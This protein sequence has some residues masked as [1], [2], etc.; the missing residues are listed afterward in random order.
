MLTN[1]VT[2]NPKSGQNSGFSLIELLIALAIAAII[3]SIALPS[4]TNFVERSKMRTAQADLVALTVNIE[5]E[6]QRTLVYPSIADSVDLSSRYTGWNPTSND[7][8]YSA[9]S[10][11]TGYTITATGKNSLAGCTLTV[12][13]NNAR[14]ATGCPQSSGDWI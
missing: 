5:N 2:N 11:A 4:Y 12:N 3:T 8:D 7:F 13:A 9:V 10:A 6:Y 14:T 1:L